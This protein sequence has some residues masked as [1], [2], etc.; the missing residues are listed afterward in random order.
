MF[1]DHPQDSSNNWCIA[2]LMS[3]NDKGEYLVHYKG[4]SEKWD[5]V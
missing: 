1:D 2:Q 5:E 3:M 4:W